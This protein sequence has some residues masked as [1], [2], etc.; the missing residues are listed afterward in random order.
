MLCE[1]PLYM[2]HISADELGLQPHTT[3]IPIC[4]KNTPTSAPIANKPSKLSATKVKK[5]VK[6][7]P[8]PN[9]MPTPN[10]F[11]EMKTYKLTIKHLKSFA[12]QYKIKI[13]PGIKKEQLLDLLYEYFIHFNIAMTIQRYYRGHLARRILK[14]QGPALKHSARNQC[15]NQT[16]FVTLEEMDEIEPCHFFSIGVINARTNKE[17]V[18]GFNIKSLSDF[19]IN[20]SRPNNM[21]MD[22]GFY[23][24]YT[25]VP[26]SPDTRHAIET[27]MRLRGVV[28]GGKCA[29]QVVDGDEIQITP[30]QKME[31]NALALFQT[32]NRLDN[33]SDVNWFLNLTRGDTIKFVRE[34]LDIWNHRAEL[35][36]NMRRELCPPTGNLFRNFLGGGKKASDRYFLTYLSAENDI[37]RLKMR[38][39][40]FFSQLFST[41]ARIT[42]ANQKLNAIY[43]LSALTLA[44]PAAANAMPIYYLSVA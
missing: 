34:F 35:S 28:Y 15:I 21:D 16:D 22:T 1:T 7:D 12:R 24:P 32:M 27:F 5:E 2:S 11:R 18:Y 29:K 42:I 20:Q 4:K 13:Q 38:V 31:L 39:L 30:T 36:E 33:Y 43:I 23:N 14:L 37:C 8:L 9:Y 3:Q 10:D 41:D 40:A 19:V 26:F 25:R 44:S 17:D 6:K